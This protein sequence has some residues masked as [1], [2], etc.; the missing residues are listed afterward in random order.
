MLIT[1]FLSAKK[2]ID[3]VTTLKQ[4][5]WRLEKK[6]KKQ[7]WRRPPNPK[8]KKLKR[9]QK[10]KNQNWFEAFQVL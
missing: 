6:P 8:R 7:L 9:M 4:K 3:F 10:I 2:A 1:I 5:K